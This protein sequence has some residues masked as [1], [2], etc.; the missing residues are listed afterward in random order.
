MAREATEDAG[1]ASGTHLDTEGH[2]VTIEIPDHPA[3]TES[4]EF[5]A[6]KRLAKKILAT[7]PN[8][9]FGS[10]SVQMHHGGSLWAYDGQQWR[11]YL[12]TLG[13]EWSSQ[14][15]ADPA[16]VDL[17]RVNAHALYQAFPLTVPEMARLGYKNA[18]QI[19]DTPITDAKGVAVWVD[20]I[21][22]SCVPLSAH[23]H[24]GTR[25]TGAGEH[26]YPRPITN[27][28]FIKRDDFVLWH[29][30]PDSGTPVAVVPT[31]TPESG[32]KTVQVVYAQPGTDLH[33]KVKKAHADGRIHELGPGHPITKKALAGQPLQRS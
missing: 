25:P 33:V 28:E 26:E 15:C 21:F 17:L 22:N 13:I 1:G 32:A 11:L 8:W 27:I 14:F 2:P 6:S 10:D 18:Q 16:K 7:I 30:D 19:L 20:S 23:W 3:R 5:R 29:D 31:G 9:L 12:N 24:T 4:P